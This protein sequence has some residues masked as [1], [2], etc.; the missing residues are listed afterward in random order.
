[1]VNVSEKKLEELFHLSDMSEDE[2]LIFLSDIGGLILESS[3]LR[4]LTESDE[5]TA[6]HFSHMVDAYADKDGLHTILAET[7]PMF[8][9]ILEEETEAFREE[10]IRVLGNNQEDRLK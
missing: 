4:F 1:M 3:V 5:D 10:A 6:D 7:F 8:K 9:V 2:K